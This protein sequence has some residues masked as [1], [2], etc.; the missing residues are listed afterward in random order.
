[1]K[2]EIETFY[3]VGTKHYISKNG[4]I[5]EGFISEIIIDVSVSVINIR[6]S[7][8]Y[9]VSREFTEKELKNLSETLEPMTRVNKP[10]LGTFFKK[11]IVPSKE[12]LLKK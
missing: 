7:I 11:D 5:Y 8:K 12:K 4:E 2:H 9:V 10:V 1:M 6:T 3:D